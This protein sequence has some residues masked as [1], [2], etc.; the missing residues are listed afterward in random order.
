MIP[1]TVI[2]RRG[3]YRVARWAIIVALLLRPLILQADTVYMRNGQV[4][5]GTIRGQDIKSITIE[6]DSGETQTIQKSHI[7]RIV[8]GETQEQKDAARKRQE[9]M[10]ALK[11][12]EEEQKRVEEEK[13]EELRKAEA[14]RKAAEEKKEEERRQ[15]ALEQE[16]KKREAAWRSVIPGWGQFHLDENVRG[17]GFA[18]TSIAL[19]VIVWSEGLRERPYRRERDASFVRFALANAAGNWAIASFYLNQAQSSD[20]RLRHPRTEKIAAAGL[21]GGVYV[22][23]LF[24]AINAESWSPEANPETRSNRTLA[25]LLP[26]YSQMQRQSVFG[27][28]LF[29]SFLAGGIVSLVAYGEHDAWHSYYRRTNRDTLAYL[30]ASPDRGIRDTLLIANLQELTMARKFSRQS[31]N[32]F[33]IAMGVFAAS[34]AVNA[35]DLIFRSDVHAGVTYTG[36]GAAI[37]L[38]AAF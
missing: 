29:A 7:R 27:T 37:V 17:A 2:L 14:D 23:N 26:G 31:A 22:W 19:A 36:G 38:C 5:T 32:R 9:E 12:K 11:L 28:S 33:N 25:F 30:S 13:A 15:I 10:E 8:H 16:R 4:L 20:A 1:K 6:L 21:F 35:L 24:D 18:S 3:S 34:Y